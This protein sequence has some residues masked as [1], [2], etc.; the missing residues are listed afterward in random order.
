MTATNASGGGRRS[1]IALLATFFGLFGILLALTAAK[2]RFPELYALAKD[3]QTCIAGLIGFGGLAWVTYEGALLA[4]Q[5]DKRL[6][7]QAVE[8]ERTKTA[9]AAA[10]FTA[11]VAW[12]VAFSSQQVITVHKL[13]KD[14]IDRESDADLPAVAIQALR[15]LSHLPAARFFEN[16]A[17]H[18][19]LL[20]S[21]L[22]EKTCGFYYDLADVT[23]LWKQVS[24][25]N[26]VVEFA[27]R[28]R[29]TAEL[30]NEAIKSASALAGA[31]H[32]MPEPF[33]LTA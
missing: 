9:D 14:A 10:S 5:R 19:V 3:W 25:R 18:V 15:S 26:D 2:G 13:L 24:T 30:G 31:G 1:L 33:D 11:I 12:E 23:R 17:A 21:E 29:L 28:L 6:N 16:S 32:K 22:V 4:D 27:D 8:N 20:P 7:T